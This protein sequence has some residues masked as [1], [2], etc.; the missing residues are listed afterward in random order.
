M[1]A[2]VWLRKRKENSKKL[3]NQNAGEKRMKRGVSRQRKMRKKDNKKW[4][5]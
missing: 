1:N 3:L 5:N 2:A 4:L